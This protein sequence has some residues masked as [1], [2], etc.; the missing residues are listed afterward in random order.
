[1]TLP[2]R[3]RRALVDIVGFSE[4]MA[5][6]VTAFGERNLVDDRPTQLVAEALLHRIGEAVSR[7]D[8]D[9]VALH[10]EVPWRKIK[11]LRTVVAH[12]YGFIDYG[13]V[14]RVLDDSL[15]RDV[16]VIR[17]ILAES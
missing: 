7:L 5:S 8:A 12:E 1:M 11:A 15:P 13:L 6:Y 4:E 3:T 10:D 14:W 17:R 9:F 2:D 16:T